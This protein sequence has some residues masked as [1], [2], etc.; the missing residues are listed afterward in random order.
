[1]RHIPQD[2]TTGAVRRVTNAQG[3]G[4]AVFVV[5]AL[6]VTMTGATSAQAQETPAPTSPAPTTP[7]PTSPAP[8]MSVPTALPE[9]AVP[10]DTPSQEA[11]TGGGVAPTT[12][13]P[14]PPLPFAYAPE[15]SG[16]TTTKQVVPPSWEVAELN[17]NE[18]R[19][20]EDVRVSEAAVVARGDALAAHEAKVVGATE[21]RDVVAAELVVA[22]RAQRVAEVARKE[23]VAA[24]R[25]AR[26]IL[27]DQAVGA[28]IHLTSRSSAGGPGRLVDEGVDLLSEGAAATMI[29]VVADNQAE[30]VEAARITAADARD[31]LATARGVTGRARTAHKA[32]ADAHQSLVEERDRPGGLSDQL[33]AAVAAVSATKGA[34]DAFAA[35]GNLSAMGRGAGGAQGVVAGGGGSIGAMLATR[36]KTQPMVAGA[37][38]MLTNPLSGLFRIGSPFGPRRHPI[39]GTAR[40]HAGADFAAPS[41]TPVIA[42]AAGVVV[43]AGV[44]G[45]YGNA[46]VIDHGHGIATLYA[47]Q[48]VLVTRVGDTVAAGQIVGLVGSTG[49]STGPHLHFEVRL[50]GTPVDP[51]DYL[52]A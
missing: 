36:Q 14:P 3:R 11:P 35:D 19:L 28:Y 13:A 42:A 39:Y 49:A 32:A 22:Q 50:Y 47:H 51:I 5:A 44:R 4:M 46:V 23:A 34:V 48:S 25:A 31:D 37:P 33:A 6:A 20:L 24:H 30:T 40:L 17:M 52:G 26:G 12:T 15:P 45:G 41:G 43:V 7:A 2:H 29:G 8:T 18:L 10:E 9:D 1:M 38:G 27:S 21:R 16:T